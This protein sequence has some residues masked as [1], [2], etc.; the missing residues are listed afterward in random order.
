MEVKKHLPHMQERKVHLEEA[1]K[2]E[3]DLGQSPKLDCT[4]NYRTW[5]N[6]MTARIRPR[7]DGRFKATPTRSVLSVGALEDARRKD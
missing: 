4:S 5:P 3:T 6:V 1:R 7:M 2:A